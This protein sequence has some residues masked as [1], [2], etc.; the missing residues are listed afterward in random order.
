MTASPASS[1]FDPP[2]EIIPW[3]GFRYQSRTIVVDVAEEDRQLA[4]CGI[5]PAIY[6]G[7][8]DPSA[9]ISLA[10]QEG[11]RNGISAN[12]GVNM[13]QT[14]MQAQPLPRGD[15]LTVS[16]E[17]LAVQP[18]ARGRVTTSDTRYHRPDGSLGITSRRT[19]LKTDPTVYADPAQRGAGPRPAPLMADV[20]TLRSLGGFSLRPEDVKAYGLKTTNPIH[21]DE[22]AAR[23]A[24]YRA[25]IIGGGHGVRFLMAAL[26]AQYAPAA[27]EVDIHFRRPL[28]W[29]DDV[30]ILVDDSDSIWPAM[31]L[32]R[33]GKVA[34]EMNIRTLTHA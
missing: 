24:G 26:W 20:S 14:L 4:L 28:F 17:I 16:G 22:E 23:R 11:V 12:G 27:I 7:A 31:C 21:F 33:D 13:V 25:P 6:R 8:L 32:A 29:D 34:T 1:A 19:S 2:N 5:D 9:F 3:A 30:E 10:I 15:T 18:S